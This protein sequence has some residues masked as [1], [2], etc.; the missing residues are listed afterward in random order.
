MSTIHCSEL[1][2]ASRSRA[3]VGSA[4]FKLPLA[5]ITIEAQAQHREDAPPAGV[6][7]GVDAAEVVGRLGHVGS[8]VVHPSNVNVIAFTA[9]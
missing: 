8:F 3:S 2:D 6:D 7:G 9:L 4:T 1:L 5:T